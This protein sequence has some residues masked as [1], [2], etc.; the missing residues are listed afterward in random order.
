MLVLPAATGSAVL[1]PCT[2]RWIGASGAWETAANWRDEGTAVSRVPVATDTVCIDDGNP[3]T[4]LVVTTSTG[5]TVAGH[6]QRRGAPDRGQRH[7]RPGRRD[8][9]PWRVPAV[10]RRG[11][12][13]H[14]VVGGAGGAVRQH[15]DVA[16]DGYN[17]EISSGVIVDS[18][19][20]VDV[21]GWRP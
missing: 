12:R 19:G 18:P 20:T 17:N 10:D 13:L 11:R 5:K 15:R 6:R 1:G 2:I 4:S 16:G 9:Q 3:L 14:G 7:D 8:R 21:Q